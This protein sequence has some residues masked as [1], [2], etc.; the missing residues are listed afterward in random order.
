M[1]RAL[2][3]RAR[4]V[5]PFTTPFGRSSLRD[6]AEEWSKDH[7]AEE[8]SKDHDAEEWSKDHDAEEWSKDHDRLAP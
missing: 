3:L 4:P 6:D 5:R 8:W 1:T 7:D 2:D